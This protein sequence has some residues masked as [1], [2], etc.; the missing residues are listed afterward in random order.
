MPALSKGRTKKLNSAGLWPLLFVGPLMAGVVLFYHYPIVRNLWTSFTKTGPFGGNAEFVWF[1]NYAQLFSRPDLYSALGNTLLYSLAVLISI[2]IAVMVAAA[3]NMPGLKGAG[4][5]RAMYFMPYL[6][7]PVAIAMVWKIAFNG[8]FGLVNQFLRA[9]GVSNPPYWITTPGFALAVICF[10][11]IW[12]SIGFNVIILSAGIKN[13]SA[14]L[15]EAAELDGAGSVRQFFN[16]TLPL[17]TPSI[18]F[19]SVIQ[20][21]AGLQLFDAIYAMLGSRNPA[22]PQTRSLVYFF[23]DEAFIHNDKGAGAAVAIVI[24]VLVAL[25]TLVQFI[26]QK[27]WVNY[28]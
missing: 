14:E 18:F 17:L 7:M 5:Y 8:E 11:G 25:V 1:D 20:T 16:I 23:Y 3:T 22:L 24:M 27:K 13:I 10:Y 9:I 26:G 21:I 6:A 28:A 19:L 4:F 15:Y 2:P 12:M